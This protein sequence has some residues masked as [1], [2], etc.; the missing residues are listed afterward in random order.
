MEPSEFEVEMMPCM[1]QPEMSVEES[2]ELVDRLYNWDHY[3]QREV[4]KEQL[5]EEREKE[6]MK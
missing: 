5:D 3:K 4:R 2:K 1:M 6:A